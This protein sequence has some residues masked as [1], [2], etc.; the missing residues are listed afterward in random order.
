MV[1]QSCR[2]GYV[3]NPKQVKAIFDYS[4]KQA[5]AAKDEVEWYAKIKE[6]ALNWL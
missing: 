1:E 2:A 6:K 3:P 5:K 4:S